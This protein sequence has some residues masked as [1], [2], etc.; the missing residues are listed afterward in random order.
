M[1]CLKGFVMDS[2]CL[3]HET[4]ERIALKAA[5]DQSLLAAAHQPLN[6]RP[7]P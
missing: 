1:K 7:N 3:W 5:R 2:G 6:R 4:P